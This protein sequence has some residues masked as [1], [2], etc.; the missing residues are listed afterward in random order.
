MNIKERNFGPIAVDERSEMLMKRWRD[1]A[2]SR[3]GR[4]DIIDDVTDDEK[5]PSF[6]PDAFQANETSTYLAKTWLRQA[7]ANKASN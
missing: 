7:R 5:E 4:V 6:P 1:K 2:R 3:I